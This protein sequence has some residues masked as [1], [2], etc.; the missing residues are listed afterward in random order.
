MGY[1]RHRRR[2]DFCNGEGMWLGRRTD[3]DAQ[4]LGKLAIGDPQLGDQRLLGILLLLNTTEGTWGG[5][6]SQAPRGEV[7]SWRQPYVWV[8]ILH[9]HKLPLVR[10][11]LAKARHVYRVRVKA[12][13]INSEV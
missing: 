9:G 5:V 7:P 2:G 11:N 4:L 12:E 3:R 13:T 10:F 1:R 6:I 8:A